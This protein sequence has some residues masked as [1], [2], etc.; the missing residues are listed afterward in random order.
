MTGAGRDDAFPGHRDAV[1]VLI[2][3]GEPFGDVEDWI[4]ELAELNTDERAALWLFAFFLRDS[5][6]CRRRPVRLAAGESADRP[7]RLKL[8]ARAFP[9]VMVRRG[10]TMVERVA[11][12]LNRSRPESDEEGVSCRTA[13]APPAG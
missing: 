3:T 5:A 6:A 9:M 10:R 7:R 8:R 2:E 12:L 4:D 1:T 11:R 13:T